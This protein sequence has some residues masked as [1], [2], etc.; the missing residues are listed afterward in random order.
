MTAL[1]AADCREPRIEC[2]MRLTVPIYA[3]LA[4]AYSVLGIVTLP[5]PEFHAVDIV[6]LFKPGLCGVVET[7]CRSID[8]AGVRVFRS[9]QDSY[10]MSKSD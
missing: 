8:E 6:Y 9:L 2:D 10:I 3:Q 1:W 4:S 5:V 7:F